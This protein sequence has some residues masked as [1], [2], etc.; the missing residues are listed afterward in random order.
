GLLREGALLVHLGGVRGDLVLGDGAHRRPQL[1][2][3][4]G[5]GEQ[6]EAHV[7]LASGPGSRG[8]WC[9]TMAFSVSIG[10][11]DGRSQKRGQACRGRRSRGAVPG[12]SGTTWWRRRSACSSRP[13]TSRP[14]WATSRRPP[15]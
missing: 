15:G 10:D 4:L 5:R 14:P 7:F 3:F 1:L 8:T 11:G 13:A 6:V 2:V 12:R 9:R